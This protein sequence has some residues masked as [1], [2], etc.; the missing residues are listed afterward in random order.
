VLNRG[1]RRTATVATI[2]M[3]A[4][5]GGCGGG[6]KKQ[7]A[8]AP[9]PPVPAATTTTTAT[10]R[11]TSTA[12]KHKS[13]AHSTTTASSSAPLKVASRYTCKGK[14]LRGLSA[15]GPVKV[16]PAVVKPGQAFTVTV[17]DRSAKVADVSLTGVASVP[18]V[19]HGVAADDGLAA[20]L[21]MPAGASCGNKLLE[22]EG[23][24]SAEAYVGVSG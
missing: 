3:L 7:Q 8:S 14:P 5:L 23:D 18:I 19:A 1:V 9:A 12:A 16:E 10:T 24:V 15:S 13:R 4:A 17:T 11:T 6:S 20:R 22:I 21:K 2:V